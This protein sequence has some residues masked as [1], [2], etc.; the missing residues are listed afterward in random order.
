MSLSV[1]VKRPVGV[2]DD[3]A[4]TATFI[5]CTTLDPRSSSRVRA[6]RLARILRSE[7][8]IRGRSWRTSSQP[9]WLFFN[10][11]AITPS[12]RPLRRTAQTTVGEPQSVFSSRCAM[13]LPFGWSRRV[14]PPFGAI[15]ASAPWPTGIRTATL[16]AV[17]LVSGDG[18][19][20]FAC[21]EGEEPHPMSANGNR[22]GSSRATLIGNEFP[23]HALAHLGGNRRL[24]QRGAGAEAA[25]ARDAA[26]VAGPRRRRADLASRAARTEDREAAGGRRTRRDLDRPPRVQRA[27][28]EGP[29]EGLG[30]RLRARSRARLRG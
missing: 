18:A 25:Q 5:F 3:G 15:T 16:P 23:R 20:C 2:G 12:Q 1:T 24:H 7:R 19:P 30:V 10:A 21:E 11:V 22:R 26:G 28:R 17:A 14:N 29:P 13:T 8:H 9:I 27:G 4:P 6:L